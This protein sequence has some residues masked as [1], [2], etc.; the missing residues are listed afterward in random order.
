MKNFL[1]VLLLSLTAYGAD[2]HSTPILG[3][4][5]HNPSPAVYDMLA[6]MTIDPSMRETHYMAGTA[7][8]N[9]TQVEKGR[10]YYTKS[11]Q[12][13]PWDVNLYDDNYIYLW[14][15]E[16]DWGNPSSYKAFYSPTSGNFNMPLVPV[17]PTLAFPDRPS[18]STTRPF[19][20]ILIATL[21]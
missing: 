20:S 21:M 17:A 12:G 8:P 19:R 6:W 9:Y 7:N 14:A 10:F 18:R 2:S 13:Y 15:T 11:A 3:S 4:S 16:L 5:N 1:L